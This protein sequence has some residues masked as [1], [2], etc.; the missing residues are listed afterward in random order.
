VNKKSQPWCWELCRQWER[1]EA[2][3]LLSEAS[4]FK[5][6]RL[7]AS[8]ERG[9]KPNSNVEGIDAPIEQA[10]VQ[11]MKHLFDEKFA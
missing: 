9:L 2:S 8:P 4:A 1:S 7:D 3:A 5:L 11:H 10:D 6:F